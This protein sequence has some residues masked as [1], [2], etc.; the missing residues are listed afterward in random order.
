MGH[1]TEV[2]EVIIRRAREADAGVM[3]AWRNLPE[4][5][6]YQPLWPVAP[7]Q[8]R[9]NIRRQS[10]FSLEEQRGRGVTWIIESEGNAAGWVSLRNVDWYAKSASVGFS[11]APWAQGQGIARRGVAMV[12]D[13]AFM[14]GRMVRV[15]ADCDVEN[16]R[17]QH[18]LEALGFQREGTMR[19]FARMPQGRRDFYLYSLLREEW[20]AARSATHQ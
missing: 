4:V 11:V 10:G 14:P 18:L 17:S 15:E 6:R 3:N 9:R 12:L 8:L 1:M 7:A 20:Q 2:G 13:L 16:E 5:R 19:A